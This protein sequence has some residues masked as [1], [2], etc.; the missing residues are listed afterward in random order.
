MQ[1]PEKVI[2]Q[3]LTAYIQDSS[4]T[5]SNFLATFVVANLLVLKNF[6]MDKAGI[7]ALFP[8][9][10]PELMSDVYE[11]A[12][13]RDFGE[14]EELLKS[15][16][17][18]KS[19]ILILDGLVKVFREDE[20]GNEIFVYYLSPGQACALSII[21]SIQNK[22]S[23]IK[24]RAVKPT[25][26]LALPIEYVDQ[27]MRKHSSWYNF[28]LATYRSRMEELLNTVDAIA[29]RNMDERLVLY[30]KKHHQMSKSNIIPV[31]HAQIA[32]ELNTSREV[33]SRLLKKLAEKG[34]IKIN[35]QNI[36]ITEL[37]ALDV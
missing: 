17:N 12:S 10:T 26:V 14:G 32:V 19:T 5:G 8:L 24:A 21:C 4:V 9:F 2:Q 25:E 27:W 30:L 28:V 35:R 3:A 31:T 34:F 36:D 1:L 37:H 15:G 33:V 7:A 11:H 16:Q 20:N 29:F 6:S 18:I 13:F 23:E 22:T